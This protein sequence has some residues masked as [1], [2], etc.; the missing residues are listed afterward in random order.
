M[1]FLFIAVPS[2][3]LTNIL[4]PVLSLIF[5]LLLGKGHIAF[6]II[7]GIRV[8]SKILEKEKKKVLVPE[9]LLLKKNHYEHNY[10]IVQIRSLQLLLFYVSCFWIHT[11]VEKHFNKLVL[12]HT[13]WIFLFCFIDPTIGFYPSPCP[14]PFVF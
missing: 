1:G 14:V 10:I 3:N 11:D 13:Q 6:M 4:I 12:Q 7:E 9:G 5:L 8:Q 2:L